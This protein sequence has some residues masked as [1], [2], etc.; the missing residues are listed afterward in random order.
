MKRG[1][2]VVNTNTRVSSPR[3]SRIEIGLILG[4]GPRGVLPP[5][6]RVYRLGAIENWHINEIECL[7]LKV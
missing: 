1:D 4:D 3:S 2:L 6:V 7:T 5:L